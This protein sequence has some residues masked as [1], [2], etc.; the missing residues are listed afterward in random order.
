MLRLLLGLTLLGHSLLLSAQSHR[1]QVL[2]AVTGQPLV[3]VNLS[4]I[5][6]NVGATTDFNGRFELAVAP[7]DSVRI[8]YVGYEDQIWIVSEANFTE[9]RLQV[10]TTTLNEVVVRPGENPAWRIIRQVLANRPLNDPSAL[11]G[12]SYRSYR[13]TIMR[14]DSSSPPE[15]WKQ[16]RYYQKRPDRWQRDSPA[17]CSLRA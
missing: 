1:G 17:S 15:V 6:T 2:D 16:Q 3:F 14:V 5:G 9:L 13:K 10:S 8:S 12:Y 4:V 11:P 7:G